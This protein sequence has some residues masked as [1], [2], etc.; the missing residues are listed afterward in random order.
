[1]NDDAKP[2][3]MFYL[4]VDVIICS[5][6]ASKLYAHTVFSHD[7]LRSRD[8]RN[9]KQCNVSSVLCCRKKIYRVKGR[10]PKKKNMENSIWGPDLPP[11]LPCYGIFIYFF[12]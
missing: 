4:H 9:S 11:S 12:F 7:D 10:V 3:F 2:S 8:L 1:M 5:L 6:S